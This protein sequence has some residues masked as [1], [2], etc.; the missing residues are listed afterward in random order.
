MPKVYTQKPDR[1]LKKNYTGVGSSYEE[2]EN[3]DIVIDT[4]ESTIEESVNML[5]D[6]LINDKKMFLNK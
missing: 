4:S 6:Y 3:P 1:E 5:V 2:P